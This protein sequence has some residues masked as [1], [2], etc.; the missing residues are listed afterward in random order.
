MSGVE[1]RLRFDEALRSYINSNEW[2]KNQPIQT[3][4]NPTNIQHLVAK[5]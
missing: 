4:A 2:M 5:E 1:R 3:T